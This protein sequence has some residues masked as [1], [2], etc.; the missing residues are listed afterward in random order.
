M[1]IPEYSKSLCVRGTRHLNTPSPHSPEAHPNVEQVPLSPSTSPAITPTKSLITPPEGHDT[2]NL[3][4]CH[5]QAPVH[6]AWPTT[7]LAPTWPPKASTIPIHTAIFSTPH[8]LC[9]FVP[10]TPSRS[11][12]PIIMMSPRDQCSGSASKPCTFISFNSNSNSK[13]LVP[14][15]L[16]TTNSDSP[17]FL[18][19]ATRFDKARPNSPTHKENHKET[20]SV[21]WN[22]LQ[23]APPMDVIAEKPLSNSE[24]TMHVH[25]LDS[26][27]EKEEVSSSSPQFL[28]EGGHVSNTS[29]WEEPQPEAIVALGEGVNSWKQVRESLSEEDHIQK[30]P[31]LSDSPEDG[32]HHDRS[33]D[34]RE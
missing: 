33:R 16:G 11:P 5:L 18:R 21:S 34:D 10:S 23:T 2:F 32:H 12:A 30:R 7:T 13:G 25:H 28:A 24:K 19:L 17:S 3:V 29:S 4:P 22:D 1:Q 31:R 14:N 8:S 27:S 15:S 20:R 9:R 26:R 6:Q